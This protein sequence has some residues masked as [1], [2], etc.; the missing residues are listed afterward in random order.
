MNITFVVFSNCRQLGENN[1]YMHTLIYCP[2][3]PDIGDP[4]P[5]NMWAPDQ[6]DLA[7]RSRAVT[8]T[9]HGTTMPAT[10]TKYTR[11]HIGDQPQ[12]T[13]KDAQRVRVHQ[14]LQKDQV[15]ADRKGT[16]L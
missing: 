6:R 3:S 12:S 14:L 4:T 13:E 11:H 10:Y 2:K 7:P 9:K 8:G 1:T 15:N 5:A 16:L